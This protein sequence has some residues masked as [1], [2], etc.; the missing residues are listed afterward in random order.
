MLPRRNP[1]LAMAIRSYPNVA[2][3]GERPMHANR[4]NRNSRLERAFTAVANGLFA[5][6]LASFLLFWPSLIP[7]PETQSDV[8]FNATIAPAPAQRAADASR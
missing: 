5:L 1:N 3:I 2:A 7:E 8:D 6:L 4:P